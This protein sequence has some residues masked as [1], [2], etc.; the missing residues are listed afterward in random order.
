ME[1][2]G[3]GSTGQAYSL[4]GA[5][6]TP[7]NSDYRTIPLTKGQ[8]A[9]VDAAD[10]AKVSQKA[11]YASFD[12]RNRKYYAKSA[13]LKPDG[14]KTTISMVRFLLGPAKGMHRDHING[15]TLDNRRS[16][17]RT[18]TPSQNQM[19][20]GATKRNT[21]GYKGVSFDKGTGRYRVNIQ[22]GHTKVYLGEY[23]TAMIAAAIYNDAAK[24]F[25]GDYA[26]LNEVN[27]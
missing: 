12:N 19:N 11:W 4:K 2:S 27:Q 5:N 10:F 25:H 15:D 20:R 3:V 21:T 24:K 16:N 17:L 26:V 9:I 7:P 1:R 6:M 14:S 18:S 8:V 22:F 23:D 13:W